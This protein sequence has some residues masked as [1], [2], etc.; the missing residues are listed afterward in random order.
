V[1]PTPKEVLQAQL[2][3]WTKVIENISKDNPFFAKVIE[4]QKAWV[5][6]TVAYENLNAVSSEMAYNFF[7]K[8]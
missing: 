4:S 2:N 5:K 6:R 1:I 3:A 8:A 7:F